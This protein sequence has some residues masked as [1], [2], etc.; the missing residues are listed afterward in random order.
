MLVFLAGILIIY[1]M[2]NFFDTEVVEKDTVNI[3]MSTPSG[4]QYEQVNVQPLSELKNKHVVRQQYDYSCGSAALTTILKYYLGEE[5]DEAQT[6]DA[7]LHYGEREKI[8]ERRGFS[9]LDMKRFVSNMGYKS[10][11]FKG[12]VEDLYELEHPAVIPIEY[13]GFK[14]FV[15]LKK[16]T[17]KRVFVADPAFGNYSMTIPQF[18]KIWPTNILFVIYPDSRFKSRML[19]LSEDELRFVD[20]DEINRLAMKNMP[21]FQLPLENQAQTAI[22]NLLHIRP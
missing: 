14:H 1:Q 4:M 9:L 13:R 22:D 20:D 15:V 21:D 11:G 7:M 17:R 5:I 8:I 16:A 10:G 18:E 12:S 19:S 2:V 6:V 3:V